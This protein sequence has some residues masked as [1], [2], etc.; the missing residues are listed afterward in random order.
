MPRKIGKLLS[1]SI[2]VAD[3]PSVANMELSPLGQQKAEAAISGNENQVK[4]AMNGGRSLGTLATPT[5]RPAR[6]TDPAIIAAAEQA[7]QLE[8]TTTERQEM[9]QAIADK[10][11]I[12]FEE[13]VQRQVRK[14]TRGQRIAKGVGQAITDPKIV[15]P[16]AGAI[17]G[18][19]AG[20]PFPGGVIGAALG[21]AGVEAGEQIGEQIAGA[22][23]APATGVEAALDISKVGGTEALIEAGSFGLVAGGGK[24]LSP[25]GKKVIPVAKKLDKALRARGANLTLA[26]LTDSPFIDMLQ[27]VADSSII[28]LKRIKKVLQPRA[29]AK[30]VDDTVQGFVDVA[31]R[32]PRDTGGKVVLNAIQNSNDVFKSQQAANFRRFDQLVGEAQVD[33][34]PVKKWIKDQLKLVESGQRRKGLLPREVTEILELDDFLFAENAIFERSDIL[35]DVRRLIGEKNRKAARPLIRVEKM[36]NK[37]LKDTA[38]GVSGDALDAF[39]LAMK[40]TAEGK[41]KFTG[42][43]IQK[44]TKTLDD[45]PE[46]FVRDIFKPNATQNVRNIKSVVG[47]KT[48]NKLKVSFLEDLIKQ[49]S[50]TAPPEIGEGVRLVKGQQLLDRMAK[51]GEETLTE[52]FGKQGLAD[53]RSI[54]ELGQILGEPAEGTLGRVVRSGQLIGGTGLFLAPDNT[55]EGVEATAKGIVF[56]PIA[57]SLILNSRAGTRMLASTLRLPSGSQKGVAAAARLSRLANRLKKK[58]EPDDLKAFGD[59]GGS[60]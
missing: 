5:F 10:E 57:L 29:F 39:N 26:Q 15:G 49:T 59:I 24:I 19:A 11:G 43:L 27:E 55:P 2:K 38:G 16:T 41:E 20:G 6:A 45:N 28:G 42:K 46:N 35:D 8:P 53:I 47:D 58:D 36:F 60:I 44:L 12:S 34:R 17:I 31:G 7:T 51:F 56:T 25:L 21:G 50:T 32:L 1:P 13:A 30:Y 3:A 54:G 33:I 37:A 9:I 14:E 52:V 40:F 18:T 4:Q 48:F 23:T 22:P